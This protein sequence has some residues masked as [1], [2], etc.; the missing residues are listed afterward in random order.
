MN[1]YFNDEA[2]RIQN[3]NE[4]MQVDIVGFSRGAAQAREFANRL[5]VAT[6]NG[7]YRYQ[8]HARDGSLQVDAAGKPVMRCQRVE[9]RFMGLFDTVLSTNRS[10]TAYNMAVP[11]QFAYVAQAVALNEYR[12]APAGT[13]AF[14]TAPSNLRF[15]DDTRPHLP[16]GNHYG[17][18]PL[19]SI[20]ASSSTVGQ[21]RIER[22]FIGAHADVGGGYAA[23]ENGL[24][25]VALSW[26]VAQA[27]IAGVKM[28]TDEVPAIDMASPVIHDQSNLIRFGNPSTAPANFEVRGA[29]W[30]TNTREVEDR[31]VIGGL[32][33]G[34][35]RTQTFGPAA[36]GGNRSMVNANT[37]EFIS[38]WERDPQ[39]AGQAPTNE[40]VDIV[41]LRN[42]TGSVD[43]QGYMNWLRKNGYVF[44]KDD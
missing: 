29:L 9:F 33:G 3:D 38:Y 27:Q 25:T 8:A 41:N 22:G 24:S 6:R 18:F 34:T 7:W 20:G 2:E 32:G 43:M 16:G 26:M 35:Q 21:V 30:G 12:S 31:Q 42:R 44:A 40:I 19:Q 11:S 39:L 5:V 37:H 4:I 36:P 1:L 14:W 17:G 23:T 28:N 13:D 10:G 15:W